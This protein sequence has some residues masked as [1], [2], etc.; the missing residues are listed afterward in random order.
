MTAASPSGASLP[1]PGGKHILVVDDDPPFLGFLFELLSETGF[2]VSTATDG[3]AGLRRFK[4]CRPDLVLTDIVMP[5][6]EGIGF[7]RALRE[8]DANLPIVAMSGGG[9]SPNLNYLGIS[10]RLGADATLLKPFSSEAL[11]LALNGAWKSAVS[12]QGSASD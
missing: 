10:S 1:M 7:I 3:E 9:R 6:M 8:L 5:H 11:F 12:S 2:Q 4:T